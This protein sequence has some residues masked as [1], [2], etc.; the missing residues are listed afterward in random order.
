MELA[1]FE[2]GI[3]QRI[4]REPAFAA[5]LMAEVDEAFSE[6]E[7]NIAKSILRVLAVGTVGLPILAQSLS[8]TTETLQQ[9]LAQDATPDLASLRTVEKA[10]K[11]ALGVAAS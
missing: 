6:D 2:V 8:L 4:K 9:L 5:A 10:L 11:L 7:S 1:G 3:V